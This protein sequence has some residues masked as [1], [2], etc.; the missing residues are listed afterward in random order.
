MV[1]LYK[2]AIACIDRTSR[3]LNKDVTNLV[4][5]VTPD[6]EL[7]KLEE[8]ATIEYLEKE[9]K[10]A[11]RLEARISRARKNLIQATMMKQVL[12]AGPQPVKEV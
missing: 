7:A 11:E 2:K 6:L 9:L 4:E 12:G 3:H 1:R 5:H 8:M 10:V